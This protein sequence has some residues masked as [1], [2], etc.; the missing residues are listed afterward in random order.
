MAANQARALSGKYAEIHIAAA[1]GSPTKVI[2]ATKWNIDIGADTQPYHSTDGEGW[3]STVAGAF[4]GTGSFEVTVSP[5]V[6]PG[7]LFHS[8]QLV[9]MKMKIDTPSGAPYLSGDARLGKFNY[10][11]DRAGGPQIITIPFQTDGPWTGDDIVGDLTG[12]SGFTYP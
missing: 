2:I 11:P 4:A 12:G 7:T 5:D 1:G 10:P 6:L 3:Q 9:A 8:G